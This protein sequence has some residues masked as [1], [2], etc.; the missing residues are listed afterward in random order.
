MV[1]KAHKHMELILNKISKKFNIMLLKEVKE[2][3][4]RY[5]FYFP[6][7]PPIVIEVDGEN[8]NAK[9]AD[10]FFFKND[11]SLINYKLNDLERERF[12]RIGRIILFRFTDKEFPT[13]SEFFDKIGDET[14]NLL[15]EGID[16]NNAYAKTIIKNREYNQRRKEKNREFKR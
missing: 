2:G 14:I 3:N 7:K 15:K 13:L 6:T 10:G 16:E 12:N 4:K 1:S 5:D 11:L 8:H 9:K